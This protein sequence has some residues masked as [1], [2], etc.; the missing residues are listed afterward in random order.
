[1]GYA[2]LQ[3]KKRNSDGWTQSRA[4]GRPEQG[5]GAI[6]AEFSDEEAVGN[7]ILPTGM[8]AGRAP[9]PDAPWNKALV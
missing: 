1:M 6:D 7:G 4:S 8:P 3:S 2:D 5:D 9:S